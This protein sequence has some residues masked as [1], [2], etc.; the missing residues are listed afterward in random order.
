MNPS[1]KCAEFLKKLSLFANISDQQLINIAQDAIPRHFNPGA[2]I[3]H[4][5]DPGQVL[6]LI[7]SGQIRIFVSG[8]DGSETSVILIGRPGDIFGELAVIDGLARSATA[9]ALTGTVLY[10]F[11]REDFR[12]HMKFCPQL[13][14]NFMKELTL[15]VRYNTRQVDS[16]ASLDV[17]QRLARKLMELSNNYGLV[18]GN[19]VCINLTLTQSH[20]ASLIGA[21]RESINK[22][23]GDFRRQGWISMNRGKLI[24]LDPDALRTQVSA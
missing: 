15:R 7:K 18:E 24:I 11:S 13:A 23:L 6:Y 20:L 1:S 12:Q 8:L 19:G 17:P 14:L 16:F 5:G 21:T 4:E 10:T 2:I 9:V 22:S 3:F